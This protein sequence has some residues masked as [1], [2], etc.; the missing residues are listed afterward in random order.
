M[1][2]ATLTTTN[3]TM[4]KTLKNFAGEM[5]DLGDEIF[6]EIKA[7]NTA[8]ATHKARIEALAARYNEVVA[9]ANEVRDAD[10]DALT[11]MYHER[12]EAWQ[13]S[14]AGRAIE[15]MMEEFSNEFEEI[16]VELPEEVEMPEMTA[17][18]AVE[19]MA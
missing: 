15:A 10:L 19:G 5:S 12:S 7:I 4:T 2:T 13:G 6:A 18:E 8:L 1:T 16:S 17:I 3:P 11:T 14:K 9:S